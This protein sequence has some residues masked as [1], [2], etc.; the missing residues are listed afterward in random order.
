MPPRTDHP[1][2][3]PYPAP[4]A[5]LHPAASPAADGPGGRAAMRLLRTAL[6][7][8]RR[9]LMRLLGWTLGSAL[10]AL[11][12]GKTLALAVDRGFLGHRPLQAAGWL[13]LFALAAAVGAWSTR[14]T[15]PW[16]AR[17]VEPMRDRLL[18]EVVTGLLHRA[19]AARGRPDGSAAVA[20]AQLTRQVEAV[21]DT[22][23]GQLLLVSQFA[24]TVAAVVTG[25]AVL[26][27]AAAAL[28][29]VPLLSALLLFAALAPVTARRQREAFATEEDLARRFVDT[30]Q[31]LRDLVACGAD[32]TAE[33]EVLAAVDANAAAARALARTAAV[34]RL[35]VAAGAH[36]PLL[37]VVLAAPALVRRGLTAG[38]V[39]GVLAYLTGTLEPALRLLVQGVGAS[40]LR[41]AVA[42]ERLATTSARPGNDPRTTAP[43]PP[44]APTPPTTTAAAAAA[45]LPTTPGDGSVRLTAVAHAY[46]PTA[47]PV[48]TDLDLALADGEHLAVVGPSGIG[49]S[50]LADLLTGIVRPDRGLVLLG[51][52]PLTRIPGPDLAR[53]RVL[54]PQD[55]YVFGGPLGDNLRWL[56][57]EASD[58]EAARSLAAVGATALAERPGGLDARID[59]GALSAGE[60]Q[61]IA[62]ARAH[63]STA[64]L[65]VLDEATRHLDAAAELR[66]E[67][68]FRARP[69]TVVTITHRPGPARRADRVLF[70]D[71]TRPAIG[72]HR[73]LLATVPGYRTLMGE[74]DG[75]ELNNRAG[76][77][78]R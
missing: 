40:W 72:T 25:T 19:V 10:P 24:L 13:A 78:H 27:P 53:A 22:A 69:G 70:L 8:D 67:H 63:L 34:R 65:V 64:R 26:A 39:L 55:P 45:A 58:E 43:T 74:E 35:I 12:A 75:P 42:A 29:A 60:R 15:Y 11:A 56:A 59:P 30:V 23:A 6:G 68:A 36:L 71:G 46:G 62:L 16:L 14:Q 4:Q 51:G 37:L 66:A 61:L 57:P 54:L 49:K 48:F 5:T 38:A 31:G 77:S 73:T 21:R 33:E 28:V 17:L 50:T 18:R 32:R 20:V 52:I 76:A 3:P 7:T 9:A 44:A 41:M 47:E 1:A 2:P